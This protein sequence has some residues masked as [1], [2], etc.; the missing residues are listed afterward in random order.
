MASQVPLPPSTFPEST[1]VSVFFGHRCWKFTAVPRPAERG[2]MR[3]GTPALGHEYFLL[4]YFLWKQAV[5]VPAASQATGSASW[6]RTHGTGEPA[7]GHCP[8]KA[9]SGRAALT[10]DILWATRWLSASPPSHPV[11]SVVP[12][13]EFGSNLLELQN[14]LFFFT[15][16]LIFVLF[17]F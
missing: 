7:L 13:V 8:G 3:R 15:L 11:S 1:R 4:I 5:P 6:C 10:R 12:A 16:I 9:L 14:R 2:A 17:F